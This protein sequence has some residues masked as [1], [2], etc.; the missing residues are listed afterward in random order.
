MSRIA[1]DPGIPRHATEAYYFNQLLMDLK[2]QLLGYPYDPITME[3]LDQGTRYVLN[4]DV[5]REPMKRY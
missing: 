1:D 4:L 3:R 5:C 2:K